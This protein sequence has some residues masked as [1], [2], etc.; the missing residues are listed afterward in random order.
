M[1]RVQE[2]LEGPRVPVVQDLDM[3]LVICEFS[4]ESG[5]SGVDKDRSR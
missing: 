1:L 2:I 4:A 5:W 3:R